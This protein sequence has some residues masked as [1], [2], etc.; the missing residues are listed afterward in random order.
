MLRSPGAVGEEIG[1]K[2]ISTGKWL[3]KVFGLAV[4]AI[5]LVYA[6]RY[7]GFKLC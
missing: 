3:T 4:I 6:I 2:Y 5:G 1:E 7:F